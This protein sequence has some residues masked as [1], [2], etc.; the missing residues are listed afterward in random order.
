M[1]LCD[2]VKGK[3]EAHLSSKWPTQ[4]VT[5]KVR[6]KGKCIAIVSLWPLIEC[7]ERLPCLGRTFE[8]SVN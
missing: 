3:N 2:R 8:H 1:C 5:E 7:Y 6:S 4:F